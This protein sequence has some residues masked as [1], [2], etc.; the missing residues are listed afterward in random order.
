M[1]VKMCL[2][3]IFIIRLG[4]IHFQTDY[5]LTHMVF[6]GTL[7]KLRYRESPLYRK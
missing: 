1:Y 7:K 5:S 3:F 2:S 4:Y 6:K